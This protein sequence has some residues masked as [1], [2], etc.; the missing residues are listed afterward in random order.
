METIIDRYEQK[1]LLSKKEYNSLRNFSKIKVTILDLK[2][3]K[4]KTTT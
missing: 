3:D 1:Y 2:F 4:I